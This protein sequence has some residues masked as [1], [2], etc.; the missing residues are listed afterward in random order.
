MQESGARAPSDVL[1]GEV[2]GHDTL[3]GLRATMD[4]APVGMAQ[5]DLQGRFLHV[6]AYARFSSASAPT[7]SAARFRS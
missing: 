6:N 7:C 2:S 1:T 5:F 4:L 3:E